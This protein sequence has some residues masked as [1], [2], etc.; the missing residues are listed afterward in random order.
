MRTQDVARKADDDRDRNENYHTSPSSEY[1]SC[2]VAEAVLGISL[3]YIHTR[4]HAHTHT[5][6][7]IIFQNVCLG[8]SV[9]SPLCDKQVD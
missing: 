9:S 8:Y 1:L 5:L 7:H 4:V 3:S 2:F 6:T